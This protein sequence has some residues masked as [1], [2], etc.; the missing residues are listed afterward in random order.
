MKPTTQAHHAKLAN[1]ALYYIYR[2]IDTDLNIDELCK[3][4]GVSRFHLQ[5]LF[6]AQMGINLYEMIQSIRLQKAASLLITNP[7]STITDIARMCGYSSQTSFIR[8]FKGRFEMTPTQWRKGGYRTYTQG[9]IESSESAS[10]SV[11]EY[12]ALEPTIVRQPE[13]RAYYIRHRGYSPA[14]KP[15]WHKLRAWLYTHEIETHTSIG[16][17]HDNPIVTPLESCHY[18]AAVSVPEE[19]APAQTSLPSFVIPGGLYARVEAQGHYGD[20]L[21]LIQ[22]AYQ[23]W[24]PRSGYE[25]TTL[26]S[27][28]IFRKNHFLSEDE[29]FDVAYYLPVRLR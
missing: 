18:V 27:Y 13:I 19:A 8:V 22:W 29:R 12:G 16:I 3:H 11:A 14:I 10:A 6:K 24:L 5:R 20:I 9:I 21:R 25:A 15:I 2:Y 23:E 26:P 7:G 28:T 1:D 4:L 17:Y